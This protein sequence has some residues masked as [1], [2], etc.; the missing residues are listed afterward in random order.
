MLKEASLLLIFLI[1]QALGQNVP[2][3]HDYYLYHNSF[4]Y[5]RAF[6]VDKSLNGIPLKL[7]LNFTDSLASAHVEYF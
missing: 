1:L 7:V 3:T 5:Y 2:Y 6:N 4:K